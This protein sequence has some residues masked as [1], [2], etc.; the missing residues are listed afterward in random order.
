MIRIVRRSHQWNRKRVDFQFPAT[1]GKSTHAFTFWDIIETCQRCVRSRVW[2][3]PCLPFHQQKKVIVRDTSVL[4]LYR[5]NRIAPHSSHCIFALQRVTSH[6]VH[7]I[8]QC[9]VTFV[10]GI[11]TF[12]GQSQVSIVD[13]TL[14]QTGGNKFVPMDTSFGLS[15]P[16]SIKNICN[17]FFSQCT[18]RSG[19]CILHQHL[20]EC[21]QRDFSRAVS[22]HLLKFSSQITN[23][24]RQ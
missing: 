24:I 15:D 23:L 19:S 18:Q 22:I 3:V 7:N 8:V 9:D 17:L 6:E 21:C 14:R 4:T 1:G 2:S 13:R 20:F 5:S 16:H 12:K 10:V 11:Q